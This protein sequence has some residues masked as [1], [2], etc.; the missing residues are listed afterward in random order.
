LPLN[1]K[2]QTS[3]WICMKNLSS[4]IKQSNRHLHEYE[5]NICHWTLS[6]KH[7]HEYV[8]NICH[9]SLSK[10]PFG[11]ENNVRDTLQLLW[12]CLLLNDQWQIFH[13]YSWRCL[14]LNDEWQIFHT[15]SWRC[16]LLNDQ[17]QIFHTYSWRCL[18][19]NVQWQIFHSYSWRIYSNYMTLVIKQ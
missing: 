4:D 9:W 3:S 8:W 18:L 15:Y 5:W 19:L 12:N 2:Q 10:E 16:L 13:T 14:L 7:L 17:W 1:I 6:N 11:T